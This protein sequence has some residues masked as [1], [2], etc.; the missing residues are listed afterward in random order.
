[1]RLHINDIF[2][3]S[4]LRH[5]RERILFLIKQQSESAQLIDSFSNQFSDLLGRTIE[6]YSGTK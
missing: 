4:I 6:K 5:L 3:P 2:N 1:M